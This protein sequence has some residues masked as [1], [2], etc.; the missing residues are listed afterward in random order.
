M[1]H[2]TSPSADYSPRP[3]WRLAGRGSSCLQH[4]LWPFILASVALHA[5]LLTIAPG[6]IAGR[7]P[8]A[9]AAPMAV[10]LSTGTMRPKALVRH[11][12]RV[13]PELRPTIST[14]SRMR[15]LATRLAPV[16]ARARM[17]VR[18]VGQA[19]RA[20][21]KALYRTPRDSR[22]AVARLSP[23]RRA[24]SQPTPATSG[25]TIAREDGAGA[26]AA[27]ERSPNLPAVAALLRRALRQRFHYPPIALR[28][29]WQGRVVLRVRLA[30]DGRI[31][32]TRVV[33]GSGFRV[34]DRSAK[35]AADGIKRLPEAQPLLAGQDMAF[36]IPVDYRL[37]R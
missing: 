6:P 10:Y 29:S 30:A 21:H 5:I 3:G 13:S 20:R 37:R 35:R 33:Q 9:S 15:R 32:R 16:P 23:P 31:T 12:Q 34:L 26:G 2:T 14:Q 27:S 1:T 22:A 11:R 4:P 8:G 18:P 24:P 36:R 19:A 25:E 17:A 28:N 7:A